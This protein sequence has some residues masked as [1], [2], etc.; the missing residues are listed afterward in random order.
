MTVRP[1]RNTFSRI[2]VAEAQS[3]LEAEVAAEKAAAL[4]RA[5][6]AVEQAMAKL[7]EPAGDAD[8]ESRLIEAAETVQA[9]FLIRELNGFFNQ[10]E[11]IEAFAIPREVLNRIGIRRRTQHV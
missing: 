10:R 1:P 5:G 9:Y 6:R 3:P 11:I 4:G 2:Q 8:R 7:A